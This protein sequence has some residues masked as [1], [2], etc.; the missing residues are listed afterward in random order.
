MQTNQWIRVL[1]YSSKQ[2]LSWKTN[3]VIQTELP[4]IK[5]LDSPESSGCCWWFLWTC[6]QRRA[7]SCRSF[8]KRWRPGT[9]SRSRGRS[10]TSTLHWARIGSQGPRS[11]ECPPGV[12]SK[13]PAPDNNTPFNSSVSK[14]WLFK[15]DVKHGPLT[16]HLNIFNWYQTQGA[17][18]RSSLNRMKGSSLNNVFTLIT[19]LLAVSLAADPKSASLMWPVRSIR[20]FSGLISLTKEMNEDKKQERED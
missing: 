10:C 6:R 5:L 19:V 8:H 14:L 15:V 17:H 16:P 1:I 13:S 20:T 2:I 4:N 3:S 9:T 12:W 18:D 11:L 7:I